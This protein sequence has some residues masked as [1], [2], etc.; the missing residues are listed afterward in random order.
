MKNVD[1]V[2]IGGFDGMHEGHQHLFQALGENGAVVVIETGYANLT[3]GKER[4]HYTHCP[5]V[6]FPLDSIRS[7]DDAGFVE[8][9]KS[10]F[11]DLKR[12]VV[13]YDFRF[14]KDRRYSPEDLARVFEGEVTV[15]DE[16]RIGGDSVHSH[17]IRAKLIIG[18]IHGAN[19]F[20][21]HNY[22]LRGR[23]VP[24]QGIGKTS[25]V[26]T[27]NMT[28]NGFLIP[29]D[30]VYASVAR[31]DDEEHFHPAVTFIGH[32][33]STDGHFAVETHLLD[34]EI[35]CKEKI[36]VGFVKR[37]RGNEKFDSLDALKI[38]IEQDIDVAKALLVRLEF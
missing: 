13:G 8:Y 11:P 24:G 37:I 6:Y 14:G 7:L 12:I 33:V 38:R 32:R 9:L 3:P 29:K 10:C 4:E 22:T 31:I 26:P 1:A 15:I 21:G 28:T 17:K 34:G 5:V 2:A 19:R 23:V 36:S 25:L 18:D 20:L 16:V 27:I 35:V 30:G